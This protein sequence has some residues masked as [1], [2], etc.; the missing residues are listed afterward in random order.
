[1]YEY[2]SRSNLGPSLFTSN[3]D[4]REAA[5]V[6]PIALDHA[7]KPA[8]SFRHEEKLVNTFSAAHS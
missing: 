4:S 8:P 3:H 7:S 1:M 2:Y 6:R 5:P